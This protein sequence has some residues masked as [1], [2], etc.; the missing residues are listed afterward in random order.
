M[1]VCLFM[2][3]KQFSIILACHIQ[4]GNCV[5]DPAISSCEWPMF[6]N[7]CFRV[8]P[9]PLSFQSRRTSRFV[10]AAKLIR[11]ESY[12]SYARQGLVL[13]PGISGR[14]FWVLTRV[15]GRDK[16]N[17]LCCSICSVIQGISTTILPSRKYC[18]DIYMVVKCRFTFT[19]S[20]ATLP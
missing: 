16:H 15:T 9:F 14:V 8:L 17:N 12:L 5:Q 19:W 1:C 13:I 4:S 7:K 20:A 10:V 3:R 2:A 6:E 18:K 11:P